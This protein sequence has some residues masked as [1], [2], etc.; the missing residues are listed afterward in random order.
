MNQSVHVGEGVHRHNIR[1]EPA[2]ILSS[3]ESPDH[4]AIGFNVASNHCAWAIQTAT[5]DTRASCRTRPHG[6]CI[7]EDHHGCM[8]L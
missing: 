2:Q 3:C 7:E 4:P 8:P 1:Q 5:Y 6:L